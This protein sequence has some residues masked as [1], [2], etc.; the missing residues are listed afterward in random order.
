LVGPKSLLLV[1]DSSEK[2]NELVLAIRI[3]I[4]QIFFMRTIPVMFFDP[5]TTAQKAPLNVVSCFDEILLVL[6]YTFFVFC[7]IFCSCGRE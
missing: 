4:E 3:S 1:V 2:K 7:G 6:S 5:W